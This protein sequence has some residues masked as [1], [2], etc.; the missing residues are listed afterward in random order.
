MFVSCGFRFE[1][2]CI[3]LVGCI[4]TIQLSCFCAQV[5]VSHVDVQPI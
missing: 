1:C 5:D 2:I 4:N 3:H